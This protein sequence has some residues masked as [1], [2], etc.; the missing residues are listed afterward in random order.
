M[1]YGNELLSLIM[2]ISE[3][4]VCEVFLEEWKEV[5]HGDNEKLG[6]LSVQ[7]ASSHFSSW[8]SLGIECVLHFY[9]YFLML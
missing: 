7:G 6:V 2:I 1:C 5:D 4:M 3:G 9:H 8:F